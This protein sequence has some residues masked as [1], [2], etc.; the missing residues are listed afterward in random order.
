LNQA[1][2]LQC[3]TYIFYFKYKDADGNDTTVQAESG[4]VQ[5]HIGQ[6]CDPKSMRFGLE[7]EVTDKAISFELS[8]I[9]LAYTSVQVYFARISGNE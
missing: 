7:D 4:L 9:D 5:C 2:K 6:T 1:G 3:G 8:N